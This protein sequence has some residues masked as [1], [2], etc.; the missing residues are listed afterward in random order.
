[1]DTVRNLAIALV[2]LTGWT[3]SAKTTAFIAKPMCS[4]RSSKA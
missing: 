2:R 1:M 3:N 4:A